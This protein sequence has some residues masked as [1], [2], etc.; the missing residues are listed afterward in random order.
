[1]MTVTLKMRNDDKERLDRL[2]AKLLLQ[3]VK[4]NQEELIAKLVD[5]GESYLPELTAQTR[6][7]PSKKEIERIMSV[8]FDM[9][10]SSENTIDE[11]IYGE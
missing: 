10:P 11:D 5:L 1:M 2:R 9:G 8:S 4:L 6:K 3:G 7:K